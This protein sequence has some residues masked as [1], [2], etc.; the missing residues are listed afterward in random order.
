MGAGREG[1]VGSRGKSQ[2]V[3]RDRTDKTPWL[4]RWERERKLDKGADKATGRGRERK[5]K[6]KESWKN[7]LQ[8][9]GDF[10][11]P[12]GY[13]RVKSVDDSQITLEV[14]VLISSCSHPTFHGKSKIAMCVGQHRLFP[15]ESIHPSLT[16]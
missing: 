6:R 14:P 10:M 3:G 1:G 9:G 8:S 13:R 15:P 2:E 4:Q 12:W 16:V 7:T 11:C 5:G